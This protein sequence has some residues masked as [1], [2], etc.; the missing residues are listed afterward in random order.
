MKAFFRASVIWYK[1]GSTKSMVP[2][3]RQILAAVT[4]EPS[5]EMAAGW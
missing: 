1:A 3:E 4:H 5:Q 2:G